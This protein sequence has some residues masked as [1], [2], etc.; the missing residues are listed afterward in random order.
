MEVSV[1]VCVCEIKI[2]VKETRMLLPPPNT[3]HVFWFVLALL[4]DEM[5]SHVCQSISGC[6]TLVLVSTCLQIFSNVFCSSRFL[7]LFIIFYF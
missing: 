5:R 1:C 2:K 6:K 3:I 7:F 4:D